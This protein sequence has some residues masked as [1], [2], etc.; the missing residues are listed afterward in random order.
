M[1]ESKKRPEWG[2]QKDHVWREY[3]ESAT[4]N[5]IPL[6][7]PEQC[8]RAITASKTAGLVQPAANALL[9]GPAHR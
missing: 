3:G 1:P 9:F 4:L 8:A 5:C 2:G 6:L 7:Q